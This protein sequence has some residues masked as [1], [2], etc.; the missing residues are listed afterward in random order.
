M[1]RLRLY[2]LFFAILSV[3]TPVRAEITGKPRVI[4]GDT[5]EIGG[6]VIRLYGID[7][8]AED[9]TCGVNGKPWNCGLE[10]SFALAFETAEHWVRCEERGTDKDGA[11]LA[12]CF[13]GPYDLNALMVRKGWARGVSEGYLR[14][15]AEA[16][17]A[18]TGL[19]RIDGK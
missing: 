5:F 19:W 17:A 16:R 3:S 10:A 8:P 2:L 14:F 1:K 6:Q 9:E 18:K 11:V 13:V 12:V 4:D 7:A 15:E